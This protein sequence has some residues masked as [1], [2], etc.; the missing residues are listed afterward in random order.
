MLKTILKLILIVC[1]IIISGCAILADATRHP[2]KLVGVAEVFLGDN[3]PVP[4]ESHLQSIYPASYEDVF[5]SVT[6]SIGLVNIFPVTINKDDGYILG[7]RSEITRDG[8]DRTFETRYFYRIL[9]SESG[10]ESTLVDVQTKV[11]SECLEFTGP[12]N[13]L[14]GATN[15]GC[16]SYTSRPNWAKGDRRDI[17][18]RQK[19]HQMI[20]IN[21][22]QAGLI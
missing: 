15:S 14:G 1:A 5:Q 20:R 4:D 6:S 8:Y 7:E 16:A 17:E 18:T 2:A 9:L 11:Q 13:A 19:F 3:L 22:V 12:L 21:L 10:E